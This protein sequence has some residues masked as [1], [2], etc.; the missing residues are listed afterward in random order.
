MVV[1]CGVVCR[2]W[3]CAVLCRVCARAFIAAGST[4]TTVHAVLQYM[5]HCITYGTALHKMEDTEMPDE[6]VSLPCICML[7]AVSR[8]ML[9]YSH[10]V[11]QPLCLLAVSRGM[12]RQA[13]GDTHAVITSF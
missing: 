13:R 1:W 8:D 10:P 11:L 7:L 6:V 5:R 2:V 9:C 12:L 3:C 4:G